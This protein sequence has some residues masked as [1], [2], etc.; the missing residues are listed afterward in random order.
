[1]QRSPCRFNRSIVMRSIPAVSTRVFLC[2][3]ILFSISRLFANPVAPMPVR[4]LYYQD[5]LHWIIEFELKEIDYSGDEIPYETDNIMLECGEMGYDFP[6]ERYSAFPVR[7]SPDSGIGLVTPQHFPGVKLLPGLT[8]FMGL[9]GNGYSSADPTLP[10]DLQ[11]NTTMERVERIGY[12]CYDNSDGEAQ[13]YEMSYRAY[14]VVSECRPSG[15]GRGDGRI[16]GVLTDRF[17]SPLQSFTV[18]CFTDAGMEPLYITQTG[19]DGSFHLPN[20][21]PCPPITLQF[22]RNDYQTCYMVRP[23][24]ESPNN[25]LDITIELQ[26]PPT[27]IKEQV[28]TPAK[29]TPAVHMP[30]SSGRSGNPVVLVV[31][32][33][34]L[35][36]KGSCEL[37]ALSGEIIRSRS[38]TCRGAGTYT[39]ALEGTD[40][41]DR[42]LPAATYL[43]RIKIGPEPVFKGVIR[44]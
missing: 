32:D 43:C 38:F 5:S 30:S 10:D 13:C 1:M 22:S 33:N 35:Q 15:N 42:P 29:K 40:G 25:R 44:R 20:L 28:T 37:F 8:I 14:D 9:A 19:T 39:I 17:R 24:R 31:S 18:Q 16:T 41:K 4:R 36:G 7:L 12:N 3:I 11:P 6:P 2:S 26:F 23:L 34:S 27:A 21:D